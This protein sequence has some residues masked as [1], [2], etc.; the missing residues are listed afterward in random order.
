VNLEST[1]VTL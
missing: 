1:Q